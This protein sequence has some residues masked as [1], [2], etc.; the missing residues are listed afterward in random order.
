MQIVV[1]ILQAIVTYIV[2][3]L[4]FFTKKISIQTIK[5]FIYLCERRK[6]KKNKKFLEKYCK[7]FKN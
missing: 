6:R 2:T 5:T 1:F 7:A 3:Y 4:T